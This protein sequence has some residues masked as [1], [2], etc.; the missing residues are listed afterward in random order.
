LEKLC[1]DRA[2][3]ISRLCAS[4]RI[5]LSEIISHRDLLSPREAATLTLAVGRA[6]DRTRARHGDRPL[7]NLTH[8]ELSDAGEISFVEPPADAPVSG[9]ATLSALLGHLL[10]LD[11][12]QAP[13]QPIPGGL[14]ITIA[15]RLGPMELPSSR[16]DGFRSA[17]LRFA[18]DDPGVLAT[19][20]ARIV[21]ARDMV[22][23]DVAPTRNARVRRGADRRRQPPAVAALRR[24]VR[25]LERQAFEAKAIS[26]RRNRLT[27]R[28]V[29]TRHRLTSALMGT[30]AVVL[31][32][33]AGFLI[34]GV[35]SA[36][37]PSEQQPTQTRS[38]TAVVHPA[39]TL[40]VQP[41]AARSKTPSAKT[42]RRTSSRTSARQPRNAANQPHMTF[43]G[44]SRPITWNVT[45][46]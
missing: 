26:S 16:E 7:P 38:E 32:I 1:H 2:W 35:R 44:G 13:G 11:E 33:A 27:S 43:A 18:D 29:L 21:K 37:S 20:F 28:S 45:T 22:G 46:R 14:L 8:I 10:G 4:M 9:D 3:N 40:T 25:E 31:V 23:S 30:A 17:L 12:Q 41:I 5:A 15:G 36:T 42:P 6:W 39:P 24:A 34:D 19:V